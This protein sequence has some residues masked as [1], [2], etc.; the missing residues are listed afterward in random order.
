MNVTSIAVKVKRDVRHRPYVVSQCECTLTAS[1][2]E[3]E[4]LEAAYKE[5]HGDVLVIV[6]EMVDVEKIKHRQ[7]LK[8]NK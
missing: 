2:D 5:L 6:E 4:D 1:L 7:S 8:E 3:G